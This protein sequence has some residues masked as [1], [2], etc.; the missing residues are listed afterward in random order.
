M[1]LHAATAGIILNYA[2][3]SAAWSLPDTAKSLIWMYNSID[4]V[5]KRFQKGKLREY[6]SDYIVR[7]F[8]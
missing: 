6:Y 4:R 1:S 7:E 3:I 8:L 2:S 5:L